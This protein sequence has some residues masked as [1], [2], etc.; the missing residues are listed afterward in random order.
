MRYAPP[1]FCLNDFEIY[2]KDGIFHLIHLQG[3]PVF[4][5]DAARLETSYGHA[6]SRDLITWETQ[7][8]VFGIS[9][10]PHFDDSAIWT[11]SITE[12]LDKLWMFYTG[13]SQEPFILQQVG[14]AIDDS[15]QC[16]RWKRY[17]DQPVVSASEQFYQTSGFMA[18][19]DPFVV[20]DDES[21]RWVMYICARTAAGEPRKNGCIGCAVSDNLTGWTVI[22]P[23]L[24]PG[25]YGEM[26][27]PVVFRH[28]GYWYLLVSIGDDRKIH[29]WRGEH[30][31]GPFTYLGPL[32]P[33]YNYAPRVCTAPNGELVALHTVP[34]KWQATDS[35][36]YMRGRLAQPKKL[37]FNAEGAPSLGWYEP[38]QGCYQPAVVTDR[39]VNGLMVIDVPAEYTML[40]AGIRIQGES[41]VELVCDNNYLVLR[42]KEDRYELDRKILSEKRSI[43]EIRI[44][45][46]DEYYEIYLDGVLEMTSLGYR[47]MEGYCN[48]TVDGHSREFKVF[49]FKGE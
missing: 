18:W 7:A 31:M 45:Y 2:E 34:Q 22:E 17:S 29:S 11:M 16:T 12:H 43:R 9:R 27:C 41:G 19:R 6:V 47:H 44:L 15:L 30:A 5:F 21:N 10:F 36:E 28:G 37:L 25:S 32:A 48:L 4:P 40:T 38:L 1:G 26:E 20:F 23:V 24:A 33:A 35:G 3:A 8:P 14:L 42:Y 49:R 13:L 39:T 46:H